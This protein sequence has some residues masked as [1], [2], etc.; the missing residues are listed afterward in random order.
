MIDDR[1]RSAGD[2][3]KNPNLARSYRLL[4]EKGRDAFYKGSIARAIVAFSEKNGGLF[5]LKDFADHTSTWVEPVT[6]QLS[7]LRGLGN[8]AAGTGHRRAGKC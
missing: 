1:A 6:H 8:S 5:S 3:F 2:V 4:A 7:R